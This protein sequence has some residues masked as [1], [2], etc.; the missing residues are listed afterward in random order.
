[1]LW[2]S[3]TTEVKEVLFLVSWLK[4]L[5]THQVL[6]IGCKALQGSAMELSSPT[7]CRTAL[8]RKALVGFSSC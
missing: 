8:D 1:M 2:S 6:R 4:C 7:I 5:F 3:L